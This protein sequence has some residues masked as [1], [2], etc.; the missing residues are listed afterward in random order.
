MKLHHLFLLFVLVFCLPSLVTAQE[1][2]REITPQQL[3][4]EDGVMVNGQLTGDGIAPL[5]F[6]AEQDGWLFLYSSFAGELYYRHQIYASGEEEKRLYNSGGWHEGITL[7]LYPVEAG[8][9]VQIELDKRIGLT[10]DV[11]NYQFMALMLSNEEIEALPSLDFNT[12]QP[13]TLS[14]DMPLA[15]YSFEAITGEVLQPTVENDNMQAGF[16]SLTEGVFSDSLNTPLLLTNALQNDA[17]QWD[18]SIVRADGTYLFMVRPSNA[19][20]LDEST[21]VR[22]NTVETDGLTF[23]YY[24]RLSPETPDVTLSFE[25]SPEQTYSLFVMTTA[26]SAVGGFTGDIIADGE[27]IAT[28]DSSN[29]PALFAEDLQANTLQLRLQAAESIREPID[30]Q[31]QVVPAS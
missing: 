5:G 9:T 19:A 11:I 31:V 24:A 12:D 4:L 28:L 18:R 16:S 26:L 23:P 14:E 1:S 2:T 29:F 20:G 22:L 6:T 15:F 7:Y 27:V 17:N 30:L 3:T 10:E 21:T 13:V 8:S 25:I